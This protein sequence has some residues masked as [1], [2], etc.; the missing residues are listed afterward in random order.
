[1]PVM[2]RRMELSLIAILITAGLLCIHAMAIV[3]S[4]SVDP[5]NTLE[6]S[7]RRA[8]D[9]MDKNNRDLSP[10]YRHGVN[11]YDAWIQ[12]FTTRKSTFLEMSIILR[13]QIC[14]SIF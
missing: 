2:R 3:A 13:L 14:S 9:F 10:G 11:G 8:I 6:D 7:L 4:T 5:L 1:M 12:A